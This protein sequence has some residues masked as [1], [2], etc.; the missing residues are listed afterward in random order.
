MRLYRGIA[1]PERAARQC[2]ADICSNG[3]PVVKGRWQLVSPKI[4]RRAGG[5]R[6][7]PNSIRT[8]SP[9]RSAPAKALKEAEALTDPRNAAGR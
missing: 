2:I 5:S 9:R 8:G 4:S 7:R 1:V 3:L 6:S